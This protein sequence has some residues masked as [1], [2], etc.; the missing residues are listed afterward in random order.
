MY[1]GLQ[2][3]NWVP[4]RRVERAAGPRPF[5]GEG[6][7]KGFNIPIDGCGEGEKCIE[8]VHEISVPEAEAILGKPFLG[9]GLL[10]GYG[11]IGCGHDTQVC[12]V[13][14]EA[15]TAPDS[16]ESGQMMSNGTT[17]ASLLRRLAL[18]PPYRGHKASLRS[19]NADL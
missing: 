16:D 18:Q 7:A 15:G 19:T 4:G 14:R 9:K 13:S 12:K 2:Q 11:G 1:P 6:A 8:A 3:Q 10:R 17:L 5:V